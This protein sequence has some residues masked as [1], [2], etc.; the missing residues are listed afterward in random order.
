MS[1]TIVAGNDALQYRPDWAQVK[2]R[3]A[4]TWRRENTD[5][6][7]LDLKAHHASNVPWPKAPTSLEDR[8]FDPQ[9]IAACWMATLESTRYMGEAVPTAGFFMGGYA[10]GCGPNVGF[11]ENTVWHPHLMD[12]IDGPTNW[13][14]GPQDPWQIK[15][16]RVI[17]HLLALAPGRFLVGALGNVPINDLLM[18]IRGTNEFMMDLAV[19]MP[20]CLARQREM[21][22]LWRQMRN[23]Y[24]DLMYTQGQGY[25][26]GWPGLWHPG[27]FVATQSDMSC[28]ISEDMFDEYVMPELDMLGEHYSFV[29]Y[30]LDGSGAVRHLPKMLSRP[31]MQC[32]QYV[33]SC[34]D[35]LQGPGLMHVYR[36]VQA[37]GR[38]LDLYVSW[39]ENLEYLIHHLRPEGLTLRAIAPD[40]EAAQELLDRAP[41]IAGRDV[42]KE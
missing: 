3:L 39:G 22:P 26:A 42:G 23:H 30:H 19:N 40:A 11:A 15:L 35:P 18:L 34:D 2:R 4:A 9:Y 36:P 17:K 6:P 32:I 12:S 5:R 21:W 33:P 14:P 20:A 7:S 41:K 27:D 25:I 28:M 31:Y 24:L 10:L 16:D 1:S 8:Y 37:A 13:N 29:W 38:C